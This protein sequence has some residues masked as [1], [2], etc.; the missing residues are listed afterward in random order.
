MEVTN[1]RTGRPKVE[2]VIDDAERKTLTEWSRRGK[3]AQRLALR[4][5]IV[6]LCA[7]GADNKTVAACLRVR[8]QTVG[9]WRAR[10][11]EARLPGL[12]DEYRSGAPR[13]ISDEI[14]ESVVTR[15]LE[16]KPA[17]A[18]HWSTRS[19]AKASGLSHDTIA[20]IWRTFGLKPHRVD[21]FKLSPD[22][23][24]IQKVRD[25]AGLY[26]CPPEHA[27]VLCVDEKS[28]IQALNRTQPLL[29]MRL[30][31]PELQTHDYVRNGVT[32]LFAALDT[33]AGTVIGEI[34]RRHRAIEFRK[35][36]DTIDK[37]IPADLEVHLI[38]DNYGTHKSALVRAWFQK[39][40]RFHVHFT[41]T[42]AS[43]INQ[44][45]RVFSDLTQKQLRRGS[46]T[47]VAMLEKAIREFLDARNAAPKPFTWTKTA[48]E[49]LA[50][51]ARFAGGVL[52][53]HGK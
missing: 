49:I 3:T 46:H 30:G 38:M 36:L 22:P 6:L 51:I 29:P 32:T 10:F 2:L 45:E 13:T 53:T 27:V 48:D 19:M 5:R 1:K 28:Q 15:T 33:K 21:T 52:R 24:L 43:W 17:G 26:V 12:N 20:R 9:R 18:T 23:L 25:I 8:A 37:A 7:D 16:A 40:P 44:V 34:H 47:S 39:R 41:P 42:Y 14:V 50:S 11:V 35:F 4:A 31:Y